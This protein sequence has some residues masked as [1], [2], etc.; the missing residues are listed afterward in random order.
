MLYSQYEVISLINKLINT[1]PNLSQTIQHRL[2][3]SVAAAS[4]AALTR[5]K[6]RLK[7]WPVLTLFLTASLTC[8]SVV[9]AQTDS[10]ENAQQVSSKPVAEQPAPSLP[11]PLDLNT[12]LN[13]YADKSPEIDMQMANI[14][15]AK[16]S[17]DG[18]QVG[19]AWKAN[20]EGRLGAKRI[21]RRESAIQFIS[22]T[23]G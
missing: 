7:A 1:P 10:T 18:N 4:V 6:N 5:Q 15:L 12:L 3:S 23:C 16:A 14:D 8:S 21:C 13:T 20:I 19:N 2:N 22:F 17:L 9:K 11:N